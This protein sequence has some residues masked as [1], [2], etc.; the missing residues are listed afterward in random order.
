[1]RKLQ[2][3][4]EEGVHLHYCFLRPDGEQMLLL[5]QLDATFASLKHG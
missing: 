3:K 4:L 1:M 5:I 2:K